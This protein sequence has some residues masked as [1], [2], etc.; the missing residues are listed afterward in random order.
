MTTPLQHGPENGHPDHESA[1]ARFRR[2]MTESR[3]FMMS[4]LVHGIVV[5]VAG[6]I[7]IYKSVMPVEDFVSGGAVPGVESTPTPIEQPVE[8]PRQIADFPQQ[9]PDIG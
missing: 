7:V 6:S 5:I 1:F 3:Y 2:R 4:L 8:Q 9:R